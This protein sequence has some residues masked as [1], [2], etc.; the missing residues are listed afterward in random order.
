MS[1]AS[2]RDTPD[3]SPLSN[4]ARSLTTLAVM[5]ETLF[6]GKSIYPSLD[7]PWK[8]IPVHPSAFPNQPGNFPPSARVLVLLQ[9][10][11]TRTRITAIPRSSTCHAVPAKSICSKLA[12]AEAHRAQ[13][14]RW[15][16][17]FLTRSREATS[18]NSLEAESGPVNKSFT[19]V[20]MSG[21]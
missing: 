6:S 12:N 8:I 1:M 14:I 20:G 13:C 7:K 11:R 9:P 19:H 10:M 3:V 2:D 15:H 21:N 16:S 17:I 18:V 4:R 5:S